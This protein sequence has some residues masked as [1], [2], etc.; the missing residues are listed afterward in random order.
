MYL[1]F[2]NLLYKIFYINEDIRLALGF[3]SDN[4]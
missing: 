2:T 3:L 1:F 4:D